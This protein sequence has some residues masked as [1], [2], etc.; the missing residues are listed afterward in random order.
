VVLVLDGGVDGE[1]EEAA[2]QMVATPGSEEVPSTG[3]GQPALRDGGGAGRERRF[4]RRGGR[5]EGEK[6]GLCEGRKEGVGAPFYRPEGR[7]KGAGEGDRRRPQWSSPLMNA[8][9]IH[10]E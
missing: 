8:I 3:E 5:G 1:E 7:E 6:N 4:Y 2:K 9:K 10:Y